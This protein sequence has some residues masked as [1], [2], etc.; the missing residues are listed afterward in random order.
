[1][2]TVTMTD[3]SSL[4]DV[5]DVGSNE[6]VVIVRD[7]HAVALL[8]PFDDDDAEWYAREHDAAFLESLVRAR[9]RPRQDKRLAMRN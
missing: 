1:M 5:L 9:K 4:K 3:K 2:K 8:S 6:E 7:G